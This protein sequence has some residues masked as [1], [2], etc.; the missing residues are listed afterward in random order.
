MKRNMYQYSCPACSFVG[1]AK[2]RYFKNGIAI[3]QCPRCGLGK[4][5]PTSFDSQAY[6]DASYFN[7]GRPD[8]YADYTG[9][10][11][12]LLEQFRGEL[13]LLER[14]GAGSGSL[15]EIGSAYGYF[16][17]VSRER[18]EVFGLEICEDAVADCH[19]R[20][21][22]SVRQ[23]AISRAAVEQ[24]PMVD[25]VV[26]LDVIEHLP[27]PKDA[28]AAALSRLKPGGLM[29]LTTGDYASLAA[30]IMGKNWR[31]MTPPQHLWFFTPQSLDRMGETLGL[32]VVHLD[33]PSKKVPLGLV[34]YQ[35]ARYFLLRPRLPRWL[36]NVGLRLNMYDA[37]R[38]VLRKRSP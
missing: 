22:C 33:Y 4:A 15:L 11:A 30:R 12:V 34:V 21:L 8:G 14:M 36:H 6:Y 24:F 35:L 1:A 23:G 20:G 28:L 3:V 2:F 37:M 29:L 9:A 17:E 25:V 19:A 13:D 27:A 10:Q 38:V 32:D 26:F 18:Y 16:L 7:G 5:C 31:L